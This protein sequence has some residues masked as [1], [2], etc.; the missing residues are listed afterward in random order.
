MRFAL[1]ECEILTGQ[2]DCCSQEQVQCFHWVADCQSDELF[3]C[4]QCLLSLANKIDPI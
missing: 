1:E 4:R 2:C 3:L